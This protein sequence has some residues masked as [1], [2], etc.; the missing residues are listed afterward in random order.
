MV[1][2]YSHAIL[3]GECL[4]VAAQ[5]GSCH[6][7]QFGMGDRKQGIARFQVARPHPSE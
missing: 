3:V 4:I 5:P 2:A 6:P 1:A 7:V